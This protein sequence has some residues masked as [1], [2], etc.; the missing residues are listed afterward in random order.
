MKIFFRIARL[1]AF[2][3]VILTVLWV[4]FFRVINPPFTSLMFIKY[5]V[6]DSENKVFRKEWVDY[7]HISAN[8]RHAVIASEDQNFYEH[9]GFDFEA[10]EKAV[11]YNK[12]AKA[13]HKRTRGAST[14]SQQ[15]AKNVFLFP[16]RTWVRKGFEVYF[17]ALIEAFWSKARIIEVYL[18]IAEFGRNI[19]G[20]EAAAQYYF[21]KPASKLTKEEAALLAAVIPNPIKFSAAKPSGYVLGRKSWI[22]NQMNNLELPE[23]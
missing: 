2:L 16:N 17:T 5:F 8:M 23:N 6:D 1:V 18:N 12:K 15:V 19:Y 9:H 14:I 11:K 13:K 7:D 21:H 20:V 10:I 22:L 4:L 3:F